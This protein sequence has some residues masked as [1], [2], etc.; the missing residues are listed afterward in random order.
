MGKGSRRRP[1]SVSREE[2]YRNWDL[3]YQANKETQDGNKGDK[4]PTSR[5]KRRRT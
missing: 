1:L 4:V 3:I 2:F 5:S